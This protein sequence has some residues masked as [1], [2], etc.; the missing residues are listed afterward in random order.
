MQVTQL[1]S[2]LAINGGKPLRATPLAPWPWFGEEE[3]AAAAA[4]LRSG[5]INY[6]TGEE[7]RLFE[8]EYAATTGSNHAV[9]LMNGTVALELALHACAL[10]PYDPE[11][12]T[13]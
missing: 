5:K 2:D 13:K 10:V 11:L 4:V 7:S 1:N 6:W 9:A 3:I 12:G 8:K